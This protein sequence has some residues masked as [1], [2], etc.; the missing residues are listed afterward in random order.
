MKN[1]IYTALALVLILLVAPLISMSADG[2]VVKVEEKATAVYAQAKIKTETFNLLLADTKEVIKI[3]AED[4]VFGVVAA[5]MPAL[6]ETEALKAQA[7]AAYSFAVRRKAENKDREYDISTDPNVDQAYISK[8]AAAEKWGENAAAYTDKILGA[9]K[10]VSGKTVNYKGEV[11]LTLYHAIS[12]GKTEN[13]KAVWGGDIKYLVSVDSVSDKLSPDYFS[14]LELTGDELNEKLDTSLEF[15]GNA[16]DIKV[17]EQTEIGT[18]K[19]IKICKKE[20]SVNTLREKLGLRSTNFTVNYKDGKYI[21]NV[22][23]YGHGVGM[24][25]YGANYMAKQ[26]ADYIEILEHYYK[27]A[28]VK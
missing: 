5:E 14:S 27:G 13:A 7:V 10:A 4:Y 15:S 6:Y 23:G 21:F 22:K 8:E 17:T 19:K 24:S 28:K 16:E 9:V 3:S 18:V 1:T 11:A 25:Q 12:S 26:G 2:K 20:I